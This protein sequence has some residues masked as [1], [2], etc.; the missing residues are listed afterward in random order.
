MKSTMEKNFNIHNG[1]SND[2]KKHLINK[3]KEKKV[4]KRNKV[5]KIA[6]ENAEEILFQA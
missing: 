3:P 6:K 5:C 1:Q 4:K 2:R